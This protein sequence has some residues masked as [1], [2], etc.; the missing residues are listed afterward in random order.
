VLTQFEGVDAD[1]VRIPFVDSLDKATSRPSACAW[2][3]SARRAA[4]R[5]EHGGRTRR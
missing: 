3:A 5:G 2:K 4:D 1:T